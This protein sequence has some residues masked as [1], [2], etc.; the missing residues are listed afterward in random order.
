MYEVEAGAMGLPYP[1]PPAGAAATTLP[2]G[3]PYESLLEEVG[4]GIGWNFGWR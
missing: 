2:A 1:S 3:E 4:A